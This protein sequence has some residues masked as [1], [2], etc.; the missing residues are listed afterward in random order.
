L[1][2]SVLGYSVLGYSVLTY[3]VLIPSST[4]SIHRNYSCLTLHINRP[5]TPRPIL[6]MLHQ[7]PHHR[8]RVHVIQFLFPLPLAVY[9]EIIKPRLPKL[10][11]AS[12]LCL[13]KTQ[14]QLFFGFWPTPSPHLPRHP[15]LQKLAHRGRSP[16]RRLAYQY[17]DMIRHHHVA[18]Q[19]ESPFPPGTIEFPHEN[20]PRAN[21]SQKRQSPIATARNK[22]KMF[23]PVIPLQPARHWS[24]PRPTLTNREWGTLRL[25]L[26]QLDL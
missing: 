14:P 21:C 22:V 3:A 4:N 26:L 23:L 10:T 16:F 13:R 9:V 18:H 15:L 24:N 2:Y 17:M 6:R 5:A 7:S 12:S 20:I 11:Q 1:G 8:I 19:P 25:T